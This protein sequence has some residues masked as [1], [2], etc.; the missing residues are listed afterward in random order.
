MSECSGGYCINT[1][2]GGGSMY[3]CC[4]RINCGGRPAWAIA[5]DGANGLDLGTKMGASALNVKDDDEFCPG[6]VCRAISL[7]IF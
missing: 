5:P 4:G 7:T 3:I 1:A 2:G 6:D